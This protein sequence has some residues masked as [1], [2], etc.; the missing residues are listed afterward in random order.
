MADQP[1]HTDGRYAPS[2]R[3]EPTAPPLQHPAVA[4]PSRGTR[5][6]VEDLDTTIALLPGMNAGGTDHSQALELLGRVMG[7][8]E[9]Y[10]EDDVRQ[11]EGLH[12]I[13]PL[14]GQLSM[15]HAEGLPAR[16]GWADY[17]ATNLGEVREILVDTPDGLERRRRQQEEDRAHALVKIQQLRAAT[18]AH[19]Q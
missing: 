5:Q 7:H 13:R 16:E 19:R 12:R 17:A 10:P 18:A 11:S 15:R 8:L 9:T 1:R 6:A 3:A 4:H 2:V 14:V